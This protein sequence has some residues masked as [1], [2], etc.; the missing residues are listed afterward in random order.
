MKLFVPISIKTITKEN[1]PIYLE[2]IKS[3]KAERVFLCGVGNIFAYGVSEDVKNRL[4]LSIDTFH[5]NGLE[6]GI[7]LGTLGHG[8]ALV[9]DFEKF[10]SDR[11]AS[12]TG[13]AGDQPPHG[14]CPLDENLLEDY[15]AAVKTLYYN[16][17]SHAITF[18]R[19]FYGPPQFFRSTSRPRD[20]VRTG[21]TGRSF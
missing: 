8:A 4:K 21:R 20:M 12:L 1:L 13:I 5:E 14:L 19:I 9:G 6:V 10:P 7:W 2:Q 11:Y 3:I 17:L 18:F 15:A 16:N